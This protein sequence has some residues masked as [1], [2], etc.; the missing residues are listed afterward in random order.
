MTNN[1]D[2]ARIPVIHTS[3]KLKDHYF[4]NLEE[5]ELAAAVLTGLILNLVRNANS[6]SLF[7]M[8][9]LFLKFAARPVSCMSWLT[10]FSMYIIIPLFASSSIVNVSL[11]DLDVLSSISFVM[12]GFELPCDNPFIASSFPYSELSP[13]NIVLL[14]IDLIGAFLILLIFVGFPGFG[15]ILARLAG[16]ASSDVSSS[17]LLLWDWY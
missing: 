11:T 3:L 9:L 5:I 6:T 8:C 12:I 17:K 14:A 1:N 13:V 7:W 15:I 2:Y 4:P 10:K 16:D